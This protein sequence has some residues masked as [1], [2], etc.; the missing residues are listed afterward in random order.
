MALQCGDQRDLE[1]PGQIDKSCNIQV[2]VREIRAISREEVIQILR[3]IPDALA[4]LQSIAG[5]N[6]KPPSESWLTH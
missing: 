6:K 1:S 4:A 3:N 5:R 2:V